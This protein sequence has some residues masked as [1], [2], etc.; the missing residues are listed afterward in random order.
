MDDEIHGIHLDDIAR[1]A[2]GIEQGATGSGEEVR[3]LAGLIRVLCGK[4]VKLRT[5]L[6]DLERRLK[7]KK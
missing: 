2:Q 7:V 6:D 1:Q 3:I 4:V 5:D